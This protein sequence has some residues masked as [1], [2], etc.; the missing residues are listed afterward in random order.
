MLPVWA[1]QASPESEEGRVGVG[2]TGEAMSHLRGADGRGRCHSAPFAAVLAFWP[3]VKITFQ[4]SRE[5]G[6]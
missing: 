3:R 5:S 4:F 2:Y 1:S 6:S